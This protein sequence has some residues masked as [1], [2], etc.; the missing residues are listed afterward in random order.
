MVET[1]SPTGSSEYEI[2]CDTSGRAW[3][4]DWDVDDSTMCCCWEVWGTLRGE[5][6]TVRVGVK[7][8]VEDSKRITVMVLREIISKMLFGSVLVS[9]VNQN[10]LGNIIVA[11]TLALYCV[12]FKRL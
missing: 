5:E 6:R 1:R 2:S 12:P 9:P 4:W 11:R 8:E 10:P 3:R 7:E